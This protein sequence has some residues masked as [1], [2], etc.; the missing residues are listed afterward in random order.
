MSRRRNNQNVVIYAPINF[1]KDI[2]SRSYSSTYAPLNSR[3]SDVSN[4][5]VYSPKNYF[6]HSSISRSYNDYSPSYSQEIYS[7]YSPL[8]YTSES[9]IRKF[10]PS[11][12]Y[13]RYSRF[14]PSI[15]QSLYY[16]PKFV[17]RFK[18]QPIIIT[19]SDTLNNY[20]NFLIQLLRVLR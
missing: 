17:S 20:F 12:N 1:R 13:Q 4:E 2:S 8:A 18:P 19:N 14:A 10:A 6:I 11:F 9:F 15:S 16:E 7:D 3:R 5:S